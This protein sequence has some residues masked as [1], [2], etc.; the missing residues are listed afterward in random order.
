MSPQIDDFLKKPP[1]L[2]L[3]SYCSGSV[4]VT[5]RIIKQK[6]QSDKP[7]GL[8]WLW[9]SVTT[10][11]WSI[12]RNI[13]TNVFAGICRARHSKLVPVSADICWQPKTLRVRT[14]LELRWQK[15]VGLPPPNPHSWGCTGRCI[16]RRR[17]AWDAF[18]SWQQMCVDWVVHNASVCAMFGARCIKVCNVWCIMHQYVQCLVHDASES[19]VRC[20]SVDWVVH[21]ASVCA[22]SVWRPLNII[23]FPGIIFHFHSNLK[24]INH[25]IKNYGI[26]KLT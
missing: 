4:S 1:F 14:A 18:R 12:W 24:L 13:W 6:T 21:G 8:T 19:A 17:G 2:N 25:K 7:V 11:C 20:I 10:C 22:M 26:S 23:N 16:W 9:S 3:S 5:I 15:K